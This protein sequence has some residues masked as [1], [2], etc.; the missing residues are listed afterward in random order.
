MNTHRWNRR[1]GGRTASIACVAILIAALSGCGTASTSGTL[2]REKSPLFTLLGPLSGPT[3]DD[4]RREL[5][6]KAQNLIAKC[7][8][9]EGFDYIPTDNSAA[10]SPADDAENRDSEEWVSKNGYGITLGEQDASPSDPN[11]DYVASLSDPQ[12]AAYY[13]ALHGSVSE[14]G[15]EATNA[16]EPFDPATAGCWNTAYREASGGKGEFWADKKYA[17]LLESMS[18]LT[19]KAEKQPAVKAATASWAG[20]MADAGFSMMK[21]KSDAIEYAAQ[22]H[23]ELYNASGGEANSAESVEPSKADLAKFRALEIDVARADFLCDRASD[24][25]QTTL[26]AQFAL[27]ERFISDH[28]AELDA[29]IDAYGDKK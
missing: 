24:L 11:E 5:D 14:T 27:E 7:M 9:E 19:A 21:K 15:E 22:K 12:Q 23:G 8:T 10:V 17:K 4:A 18:A 2:T 16:A 13:E 29:L 28:K 6:R 25:T 1:T 20:C 3:G 26:K